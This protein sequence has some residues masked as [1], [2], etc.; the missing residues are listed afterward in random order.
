MVDDIVLY[1]SPASR[2]FIA[3]WM[4]VETGQP[5]RVAL[6]DIRSGAQKQADYL[7]VN[8]SGKV[9]TLMDG[10]VAV[11]ENGAICAYL[12]DRYA[13]GRLAPTIDSLDRGDYL[14][15]MFYAMAVMEPVLMLHQHKLEIRAFQAPWGD[16]DTMLKVLTDTVGGREFLV[17][18]Q[19]T[20]ADVLVGA[21][22]HFGLF[23]GWLPKLPALTMY[24]ERLAARP[25]FKAASVA[26]WGEEES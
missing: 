15:W 16:Y 10:G 22:L 5:F 11:S 19:F 7:R 6:T 4:L 1:H 14:K 23:N 20:A 25:A 13:Y 21:E 17:G 12:A 24:A 8:P 26:T 18:N 3:Y 9:P 2:S